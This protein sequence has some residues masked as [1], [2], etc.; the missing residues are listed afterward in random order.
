MPRIAGIG[1]P[2]K[3]KSKKNHFTINVEKTKFRQECERAITLED[4]RQKIHSRIKFTWHIHDLH[5]SLCK[6]S[7]NCIL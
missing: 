5:A 2:K 1:T 4:F 7:A 3:T 6:H